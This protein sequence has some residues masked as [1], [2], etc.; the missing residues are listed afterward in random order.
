MN[1]LN[2]GPKAAIASPSRHSLAMMRNDASEH[3]PVNSTA[4]PAR[5]ENGRSGSA[6]VSIS[7]LIL[8][9]DALMSPHEHACCDQRPPVAARQHIDRLRREQPNHCLAVTAY[10]RHGGIWCMADTKYVPIAYTPIE[11]NAV[12]RR[13]MPMM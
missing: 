3:C 9:T 10:V 8:H 4:S 6:S 5:T 13:N 11:G 7:S 12:A 2:R 1:G